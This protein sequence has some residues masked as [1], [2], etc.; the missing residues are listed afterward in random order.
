MIVRHLIGRYLHS[1]END[2]TKWMQIFGKTEGNREE[3]FEKTNCK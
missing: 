1:Y 3:M 2:D